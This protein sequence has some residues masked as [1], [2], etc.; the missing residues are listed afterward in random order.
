MRW[1]APRAR[2][3]LIVFVQT[4]GDLANFN[5][6]LHLLATDGTFLPDGTFV[7]CPPVPEELLAE[8]F[9]QAVLEHLVGAGAISEGLRS[10]LLGWKHSGFS[11][12]NQVRVADAP[13]RS[14]LAG[15]MLRAP[16]ALEK[17]TYDRATGTVIYRSKMH[18]GLKRNFQLMPGAEWLELLLRHVPDRY[19]HLL[20][21]VGWYS[22]RARGER[23]KRERQQGAAPSAAVPTAAQEPVRQASATW[24]RLIRKVYEADPLACPQCQSPMRVIALIDDPAV[25]RRI[26][27]HLGR[28]APLPP[29]RS[30]P[31]DWPPGATIPL[32]Y[33]PL[34]EIA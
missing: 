4:F 6:H 30:P 19:E 12:H 29:T 16:M 20:R 34:P 13:G 26:L 25:V 14:Q 10:T 18:A 23:A 7:A 2:P 17:M 1:P 3:G 11:V 27:E 32:T 21:Y 8:R 15:Y 9:R 24:A 33:H 5:P 31:A 22:N 28:W